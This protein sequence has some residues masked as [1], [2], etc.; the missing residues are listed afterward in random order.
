MRC[1]LSAGA[2]HQEMTHATFDSWR[3]QVDRVVR[4]RA[5]L[6]RPNPHYTGREKVKE[7]V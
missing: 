4:I 3:K 1:P 2:L 7:L 6:D 5:R